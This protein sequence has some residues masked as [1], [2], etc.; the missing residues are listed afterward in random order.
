MFQTQTHRRVSAS[1]PIP[2]VIRSDIGPI[3]DIE[4]RLTTRELDRSLP[5]VEIIDHTVLQFLAG[6]RRLI[7]VGKPPGPG[8]SAQNAAYL[9]ATMDQWA[10]LQNTVNLYARPINEIFGPLNFFLAQLEN[11]YNDIRREFA[12]YARS[13]VREIIESASNGPAALMTAYSKNIDKFLPIGFRLKLEEWVADKIDVATNGTVRLIY[14]TNWA[15]SNTNIL[16]VN[17][18]TVLC[19]AAPLTV[20]ELTHQTADILGHGRFGDI[21][22]FQI[23]THRHPIVAKTFIR[24]PTKLAETKFSWA[25]Y[26][27][28]I[29]NQMAVCDGPYI[30]RA[31]GGAIVIGSQPNPL[32]LMDSAGLGTFKQAYKALR[33]TNGVLDKD[34]AIQIRRYFQR[35]AIEAVNFVLSRNIFHRDI[36]GRNFLIRQEGKQINLKL[37]DFEFSVTADS[38]Q[39]RSYVAHRAGSLGTMAPEVYATGKPSTESELFSLGAM[40][41]TSE[42]GKS[43]FESST[44]PL[45]GTTYQKLSIRFYDSFNS[46]ARACHRDIRDAVMKSLSLNPAERGTIKDLEKRLDWISPI[47]FYPAPAINEFFLLL[48]GIQNSQKK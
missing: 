31:Y 41:Y 8:I 21:L 33:L 34:S 36:T 30:L 23:G 11:R 37:T 14:K 16:S 15:D 47:F 4:Y 6:Y 39:S 48:P 43:P 10:H 42:A 7:E 38:V 27:N 46:R 9:Y 5:N 32:I 25:H 20:D 44:S 28:E 22:R 45:S 35:Q 24:A 13:N 1:G 18:D 2:A 26:F 12:M 3:D 19:D 17:P 29:T 40:L